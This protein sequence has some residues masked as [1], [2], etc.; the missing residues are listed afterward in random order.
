[1]TKLSD[2]KIT[3]CVSRVSQDPMAG[4]T[5]HL[6]IEKNLAL[7]WSQGREHTLGPVLT[8]RGHQMFRDILAPLEQG[9]GNRLHVKIGLF[10]G[11]QRQILSLTMVTFPKLKV[12]FLDEHTAAL[13]PKRVTLAAQIICETVRRQHL[14][15]LMVT[16]SMG[17]VLS[18]NNRLIMIHEERII[19]ELVDG[20]KKGTAVTSLLTGFDKLRGKEEQ[21]L[22]GRI[23]LV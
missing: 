7:A 19:F 18:M 13:D 15:A 10:S 14:T 2:H 5:P 1:M 4:T 17:Q 9:L 16:H 3:K 20:G 11:G 12:L 8:Q 22:S 6:S 21:G 23:L